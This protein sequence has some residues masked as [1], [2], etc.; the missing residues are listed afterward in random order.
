MAEALKGRAVL[1]RLGIRTRM[2]LVTFAL[3]SLFVLYVAYSTLQQAG[4]DQEGVLERVRLVAAVA[5]SRLDDN[6]GDITQF[7]NG[8][9]GAL[10]IDAAATA[11]NDVVLRS[12]VARMPANVLSVQIWDLDGLN[13]GS[14]EALPP[15][16]RPRAGESAFF[17]SALNNPGVTTEA[18][19]RLRKGADWT[20]VFALPVTRNDRVVAVMSATSDLGTL[21]RVISPTEDLPPGTLISVIDSDGLFLARS[22]DPDR[23]IGQPAPLDRA[24]IEQRLHEVRGSSKVTGVDKVARIFG[25]AHTR[26][27]PWLVYVGIPLDAALAPARARTREGIL[28][29]LAMLAAGLVIAAQGAGRISRPLRELSAD[30][31]LIGEGHLDHRSQVRTGGEIGALAVVLNR[32]AQA[33]QERIAALGRSEER[34]QLALEGSEQALFDWDIAADR[35]HYSAKSS[36]MRGGPAVEIDATPAEMR[37]FVHPDDLDEL[38]RRSRAALRGET[39]TYE[40]EFRVRTFAGEWIWLRSLGRVVERNASGRALRLVGT[41]IDITV[42][43]DAEAALRHRAEI[44]PLT[45]LPNRALFSDRIVESMARAKRGGKALAVFFIDVDHFKAVNDDHG[46]AAGDHVL[47]AV[48]Q[49]LRGSVRATDTVARLAGDEFTLILE[50]LE[51]QEEARTLAGKIVA[52]LRPPTLYEG[53]P[54]AISVSIGVA[55]LSAGDREPADLL[56]RADVALYDAKRRGR[57]GYAMATAS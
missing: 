39:A 22:L 8:L 56:R 34:L 6:V 2:L 46:H 47:R 35:I 5:A 28:L 16:Q 11:S 26:V 36:E 29:G 55:F 18:P 4:R 23:W 50:G 19:L 20:A 14:S 48:A 10:G 33:L 24:T 25:I 21:P 38:M 41:D 37:A 45:G 32:M 44:D 15:G 54:I 42:R 17:R 51:S 53:I 9:G 43:K 12:M 57:D 27:L 31:E 30:A 3:G 13:I 1:F 49:R 52:A 40:A 7:L